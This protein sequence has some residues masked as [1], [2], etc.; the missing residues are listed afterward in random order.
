MKLPSTNITITDEA[1]A[2]LNTPPEVIA[3]WTVRDLIEWA[4]KNGY[5]VDVLS[6]DAAPGEGGLVITASESVGGDALP[7]E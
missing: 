7:A 6:R 3:S 2:I 1:M 5:D 4:W